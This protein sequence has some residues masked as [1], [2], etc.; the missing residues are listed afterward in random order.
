MRAGLSAFS[1]LNAVRR[2]AVLGEMLEIGE[3]AKAAHLGLKS[4][5]LD[6]RIDKILVIG[7]KMSVLGDSLAEQITSHKFT[8]VNDLVEKLAGEL[9]EGDCVFVKGSN[10]SGI[11]KV[12]A[13]LRGWGTAHN[14]AEGIIDQPDV[15]TGQRGGI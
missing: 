1:K 12:A 9:T 2:I 4:A 13:R 3:D 14:H 10:A 7:E 11:S 6:A 15:L 8:D 5:I